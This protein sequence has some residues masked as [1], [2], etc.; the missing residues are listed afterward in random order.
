LV[1][2]TIMHERERGG[3]GFLEKLEVGF[4]GR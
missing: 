4:K 2:Y 1:H 3:G